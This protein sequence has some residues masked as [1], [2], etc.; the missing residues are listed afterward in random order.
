MSGS[1]EQIELDNEG[2]ESG[3]RQAWG[4]VGAWNLVN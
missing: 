3:H 1:K 4:L 2:V